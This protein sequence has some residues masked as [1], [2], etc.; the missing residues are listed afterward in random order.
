MDRTAKFI[1]NTLAT[2]LM[3]ITAMISGFIVPKIMLS[4]YGS[5]INGIVTSITQLISY[6]TLLEAGLSGATVFSLYKPIAANDT[7]GINR[8]LA[9]AKNLYY[10]TGHIFS[11]MVVL[12]ALLYPFFVH[13]TTLDYKELFLLFLIL[14]ING[15]LEFYTLAKYRALLTADQK[16]WVISLASMVQIIL[17]IVIIASLAYV[18][19]SI[20]I[21]RGAAVTAIFV[22]TYLLWKYCRDHYDFLD[23][24]VPPNNEAMNQRWDALYLQILGAIHQGAPILIATFF[25]SLLDVSI[26]AIF[27]LVILGLNSLLG[28]FMTGLT[29]GFGDLIARGEKESFK[30]AFNEFEFIYTIAIT[31]IY[32][33]MFFVFQPFISIYT[34]GSDISYY[35]PLFA[36]LMTWNGFA[37]NIKNP[38]GMLVISAGK[39]RETR[40]PTTIQGAIELIGGILLALPLGL[41]GIVLGSILSNVYR[42]IEFLFFAPHHLT[43]MPSTHTIKLWMVNLF[44]LILASVFSHVL[45]LPKV[46]NYLHWV[47]YSALICACSALSVIGVNAI[48]FRDTARSTASRLSRIIK[49]R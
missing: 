14:G 23:F 48:L 12:C 5:E 39:Y 1:K 25:L 18:G 11:C 21:V 44:F 46:G 45:P 17:N 6:L 49:R 22:R 19:F 9:A 29:S 38:F 33:T 24:T 40:I 10:K 26:Y 20:V 16:T 35:Y 27:N 36:F 30:K 4:F 37:Y 31:I 34:R 41:N 7:Y 42:D 32:S 43:H 13:S 2:G 3:Q 15:V 47:I 28:I 8:I